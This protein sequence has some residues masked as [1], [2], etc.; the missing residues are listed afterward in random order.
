MQ[1]C[2]MGEKEGRGPWSPRCHPSL[3]TVAGTSLGQVGKC[4]GA[5]PWPGKRPWK[6]GWGGPWGTEVVP[7]HHPGGLLGSS[8][9]IWAHVWDVEEA[10]AGLGRCRRLFSSSWGERGHVGDTGVGTR[11]STQPG[12]PA[13]CSPLHAHLWGPPDRRTPHSGGSPEREP[14]SAPCYSLHAGGWGTPG[15]PQ[16]LRG[17]HFGGS[18][19]SG[20]THSLQ[21][22]SSGPLGRGKCFLLAPRQLRPLV[23]VLGE[24]VGLLWGGKEGRGLRVR[25]RARIGPPAPPLTVRVAV[26]W[27]GLGGLDAR[28]DLCQVREAGAGAREHL[29]GG[30]GRC[31]RCAPNHE[32]DED[33]GRGMGKAVEGH[34]GGH[35]TCSPCH[36][37]TPR[38]PL[39]TSMRLLS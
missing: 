9:A 38:P 10:R 1:Q 28:D 29:R 16:A 37:R 18:L 33:G 15:S 21:S 34:W 26:R 22:A 4:H 36:L 23:L 31:P 7:G 19:W 35:G 27:V 14:G 8:S 20:S 3:G 39:L 2:R 32:R 5:E 6:R 17:P 13:P 30:G 11:R 24:V 25:P 12:S